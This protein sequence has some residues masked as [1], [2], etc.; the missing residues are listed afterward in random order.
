[1]AYIT[2]VVLAGIVLGKYLAHGSTLSL[3]SNVQY[4]SKVTEVVAQNLE[5]LGTLL[6]ST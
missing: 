5:N 1:M 3:P 2:Y 6:H 4:F